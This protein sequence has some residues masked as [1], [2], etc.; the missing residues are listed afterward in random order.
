MHGGQHLL[1][2]FGVL[3][4]QFADARGALG[5]EEKRGHPVRDFVP[6]AGGGEGCAARILLG[7]C[8]G[9]ALRAVE[10]ELCGAGLKHAGCGAFDAHGKA[11]AVGEAA[12]DEHR[13]SK[14]SAGDANGRAGMLL[15]D[16][17]QD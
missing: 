11:V 16:P 13:G 17:R 8:D 4:R 6:F 10:E 15:V 3:A 2:A 5:V 12:A 14:G 1:L 7:L 9:E